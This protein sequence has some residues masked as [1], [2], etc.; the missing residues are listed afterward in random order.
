MQ[1]EDICIFECI[2]NHVEKWAPNRIDGLRNS[3][4]SNVSPS[5]S[6]PELRGFE[7]HYQKIQDQEETQ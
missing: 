3:G 4:Q 6:L 1:G 5:L 2:L 7:K